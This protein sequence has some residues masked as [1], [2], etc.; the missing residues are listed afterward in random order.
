[1]TVVL[2]SLALALLM[3]PTALAASR[4]TAPDQETLQAPAPLA[5]TPPTKVSLGQV[6]DRRSDG[7][8]FN[9][10]EIHLELPEISAADVAAV[11]TIVTTAVDD[12]GRNLVPD[13]TGKA[14]LQPTRRPQGR[15][16]GSAKETRPASVTLELK[17][18][19]RKA[20]VVGIVSGEV[21]L[22]MP[23]RDPN[24]VATFPKFMA[25][26]GRPLVDPALKANGVEITVMGKEQLDAEKK[27][28]LEKLK[29]EAKKKGMTGEELEE[30]LAEFGSEF[31]KPEEGDVVLKLK[32]PEGRIQEIVYVDG[33]GEEKFASMT[34]RGGFAVL[35]TWG[36]KPGPDWS[37][38]VRMKTPKSLVRYSFNL[39]DVPLP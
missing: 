10:L 16:G 18:P 24:S 35:S 12:T 9:R 20:D 17:N 2:A 28:Q 29:Q 32:A 38:R 34:E 22:Y 30:R 36:E 26:A 37:L 23:G 1:M 11:R 19:A 31:L 4:A 15:F 8:F 39:K 33:A 21:E 3:G 5:Y 27:R 14:G 7:T 13:D 25:Q 6:H